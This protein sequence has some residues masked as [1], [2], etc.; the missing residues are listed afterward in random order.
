LGG[1]VV[2]G[3]L[4][5]KM[6]AAMRK[7]VE[8]LL[9]ELPPGAAGAR[10]LREER[11]EILNG[12]G[13]GVGSAEWL[14]SGIHWRGAAELWRHAVG[15]HVLRTPSAGMEAGLGK[16]RLKLCIGAS[17]QQNNSII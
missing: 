8:K 11:G 10:E 4:L 6:P 13:R 2:A 16:R 12:V 5:E 1:P 14:E 9:E 3:A 17:W 15:G 7:D